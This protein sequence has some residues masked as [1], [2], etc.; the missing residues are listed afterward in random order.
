LPR[1]IERASQKTKSEIILKQLKS[2]EASGGAGGGGFDRKLWKALL[3]PSLESWDRLSSNP[4]AL[5][6]KVQATMVCKYVSMVHRQLF[7]VILA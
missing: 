2:L 5:D 4:A 1:N 7:L 6:V 3:G